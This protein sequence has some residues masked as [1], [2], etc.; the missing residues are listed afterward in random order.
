[1]AFITDWTECFSVRYDDS[2]AEEAM[3][4]L[5]MDGIV[6]GESGAAGLLAVLTNGN[7]LDTARQ[8]FG[9]DHNSSL[10]II[11]TEGATDPQAYDRIIG[12]FKQ[13]KNG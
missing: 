5:V 9:I 10:L 4:L 3:R 6:S 2:F 13:I 1:M 11:S 8:T 12:N 7:D